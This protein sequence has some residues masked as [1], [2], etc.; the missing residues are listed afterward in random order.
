MCLRRGYPALVTAS[1]FEND[2]T[3][4]DILK[5]RSPDIT[6]SSRV[7]GDEECHT[8]RIIQHGICNDA[9]D[10]TLVRIIIRSP[11]QSFSP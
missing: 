1:S 10:H 4:E 5:E 3:I 7:P 8:S 2:E 9:D 6:T 11:V